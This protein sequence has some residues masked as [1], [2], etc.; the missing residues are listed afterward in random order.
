M[1]CPISLR[2]SKK[3]FSTSPLLKHL[4]LVW[5]GRP[6]VMLQS[7]RKLPNWRW[8]RPPARISLY[9]H[10]HDVIHCSIKP[11]DAKCNEVSKKS[12][13]LFAACTFSLNFAKTLA[14]YSG[15]WWCSISSQAYG[16]R[17]VGSDSI[18]R[19]NKRKM[20]SPVVSLIGIN[21]RNSSV[22]VKVS[23][24]PWMNIA[25]WACP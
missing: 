19:S 11:P 9:N 24:I 3:H 4:T 25:N 18:Q 21:S 17:P 14:F 2:R 10:L 23:S 1:N 5:Y 8:L 12:P 7:L 16:T 15:H 22:T 20:S 6:R 13:P